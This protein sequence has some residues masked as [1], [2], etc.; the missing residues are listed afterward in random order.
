MKNNL[1]DYGSLLDVSNILDFL[2][3]VSLG[4]SFLLAIIWSRD[5]VGVGGKVLFG[6]T[7]ISAILWM[8]NRAGYSQAAMISFILT[9]ISVVTFFAIREDGYY[10]VPTVVY[11]VIIIF[12][13]MLLG[14]KSIPY[15]TA[16]MILIFI[17]FWYL[18]GVGLIQPFGGVVEYWIGDLVTLLALLVATS[19]ILWLLLTL[20]E[21]NVNR[22]IE[23]EQTLQSIFDSTLTSWA[24]ALELRGYET[25]GH[26]ERI[27]RL[28]TMFGD[29]LELDAADKADLY[30]GALLHDIGKMGIPESIL[31]KQ[32]TLDEEEYRLVKQHSGMGRQLLAGIPELSRAAELVL[33]HHEQVDG[34][35]YPNGLGG[36]EIPLIAKIFIIIDN[37]EVL[38]TDQ[39]YRKAWPKE[40]VVQY[41]FEDSGIK[42]DKGLVSEFIKMIE[43]EGN[44]EI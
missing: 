25:S 42:F 16:L 43:G 11:P 6:T 29:H 27:I 36:K 28:V 30:Y 31:L 39:V 14:R 21:T 2:L 24:A 9:T 26:S 23:S 15:L 41:L 38:T 5:G 4:L 8:I 34:S 3:K 10:N 12:A 40:K 13:G 32:D 20:I 17:S 22:I 35:G 7:V 44:S 1:Q 37:W 19:L 33:S 18:E